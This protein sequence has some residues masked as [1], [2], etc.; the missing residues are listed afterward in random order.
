MGAAA[1]LQRIPGR[2]LIS[3]RR[4]GPPRRVPVLIPSIPSDVWVIERDGELIAECGSC[5]AWWYMLDDAPLEQ[6][7]TCR[8]CELERYRR[9]HGRA[10]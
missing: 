5:E 7:L 3:V 4:S 1:R 10:G 9:R 8:D 2:V 6:E